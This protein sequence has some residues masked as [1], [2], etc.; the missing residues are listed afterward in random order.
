MMAR[1]DFAT[2]IEELEREKAREN[3]PTQMG[4]MVVHRLTS[5][6]NFLLEIK[7]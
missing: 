7:I 6:V 5:I 4:S 2:S 3:Q 1:K